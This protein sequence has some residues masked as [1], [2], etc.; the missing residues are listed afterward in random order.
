MGQWQATCYARPMIRTPDGA[1]LQ[2]Q[3]LGQGEPLMLIAGLGIDHYAW[4]PV[5]QV[6]AT[7]YRVV[8]YDH[9]GTGESSG[10][11]GANWSTRISPG[12]LWPCW[13][14]SDWSGPMSMGIPWEGAWR[15]GWQRT[16]QPA[17]VR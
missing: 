17:L 2:T 10:Q 5:V 8:T 13:T 15:N 9:R 11:F 12:M 14:G 3:T 16:H 1:T 7:R 4:D 6:F